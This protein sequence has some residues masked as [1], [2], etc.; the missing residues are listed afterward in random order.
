MCKVRTPVRIVRR[1]L[2]TSWPALADVTSTPSDNP[3]WSG[4]GGLSMSRVR[5]PTKPTSRRTVGFLFFV[6]LQERS[7]RQSAGERVDRPIGSQE[8]FPCV[9]GSGLDRKKS[10]VV[11]DAVFKTEIILQKD[12][13]ELT[14]LDR[15]SCF[16]QSNLSGHLRSSRSLNQSHQERRARL[17]RCSHPQS[18]LGSLHRLIRNHADQKRRRLWEWR[19]SHAGCVG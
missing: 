12:C 11:H 4:N 14:L 8:A 9:A 16:I 10:G 6:Q 17:S 13:R 3:S 1:R 5:F 2:Q 18:D 15:R 19:R 7:L